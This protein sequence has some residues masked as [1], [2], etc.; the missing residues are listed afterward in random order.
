MQARS[1]RTNHK[2]LVSSYLSPWWHYCVYSSLYLF[3][4]I[5]MVLWYHLISPLF[6]ICIMSH[7]VNKDNAITIVQSLQ[8]YICETKIQNNLE[9]QL[10]DYIS[11][12][13]HLSEVPFTVMKASIVHCIIIYTPPCPI[14]PY[15]VVHFL[16]LKFWSVFT[17]FSMKARQAKKMKFINLLC[18][19]GKL[20]MK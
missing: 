14:K 19:V 2:C 6:H 15:A 12:C 10:Y 4:A 8:I 7:L 5:S 3:G 9:S 18:D 20:G 11:G 17:P 13:F 1:R 16:N